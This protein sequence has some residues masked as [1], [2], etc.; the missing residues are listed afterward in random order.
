MAG[1]RRVAA[2][3]GILWAG[4]AGAATTTV[5]PGA[6]PPEIGL[7][8]LAAEF[9]R[10]RPGSVIEVPPSVGIAGGLRALQSGEASVARL[11]RRLT[12]DELRSGG[13]QQ[14][15]YGADAV[16]FVAGRDVSVDNLTEAQALALFSGTSDDWET[17]GGPSAPVLV[18]YR[19]ATEI[20]HQALRRHIPA[21]AQ[22]KFSASAKL[23]NSD[24]DMRVGLTRYRTALGWMTLSTSGVND[25]T[26]RALSFNG[27]AASAD[28]VAS[29][30]Y[31]MKVEHVLAYK[32]PL[33]N[34]DMRRFLGFVTS[35]EGAQVLRRLQ[36][37]V[38]RVQP[39]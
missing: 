16:V 10:Q 6:G 35:A 29:G 8:A 39:K 2:L 23:A 7:R 31:P 18:F 4:L 19:E 33:L 21:F 15:V 13:L 12:E 32:E 30:R 26:I 24:T 22:V 38:P 14:V 1:V 28:A 34:E 11:A 36:I 9:T 17:V 3:L 25:D 37:A 27:V 5:I 20:A